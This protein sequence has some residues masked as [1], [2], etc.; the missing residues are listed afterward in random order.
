MSRTTSKFDIISLKV[1][2]KHIFPILPIIKVLLI[3]IK[4]ENYL[5]FIHRFFHS[6]D[7]ASV[8]KKQLPPPIVPNI[9]TENDTRN[10]IL[11]NGNTAITTEAVSEEEIRLFEDF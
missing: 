3:L 4:R 11:Y 6:L 2:N 10:Y 1:F 8:S 5:C 9:K 7:W